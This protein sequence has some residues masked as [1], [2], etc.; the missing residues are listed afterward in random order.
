MIHITPPEED[1]MVIKST[2][3]PQIQKGKKGFISPEEKDIEKVILENCDFM[4]EIHAEKNLLFKEVIPY[5]VVYN[6]R[7]KKVL[8]YQE[9]DEKNPWALS[10]RIVL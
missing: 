10:A 2:F 6:S 1:I 7:L 5:A 4:K 9:I 8:I 3:L